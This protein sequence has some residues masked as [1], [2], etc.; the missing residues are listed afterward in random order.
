MN[1]QR[2]R[3]HAAWLRE[4]GLDDR[5]EDL[6]LRDLYATDRAGREAAATQT[7]EDQQ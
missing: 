3:D 5:E 7:D 2:R 1:D 4:S 6:L